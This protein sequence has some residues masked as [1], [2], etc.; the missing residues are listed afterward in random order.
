MT[1]IKK[2]NK[3]RINVLNSIFL[4]LYSEKYEE[5]LIIVEEK[6]NLII[7][8]GKQGLYQIENFILNRVRIVFPDYHG[9]ID[10]FRYYFGE[11]LGT[12]HEICDTSDFLEYT[13]P[14][15][16]KIID[17]HQNT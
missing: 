2:T 12:N 10:Y 8:K 15:V 17:F 6:E 3:Y 1:L 7:L 5:N 16:D 13:L 14:F 4:K 9:Q 11:I